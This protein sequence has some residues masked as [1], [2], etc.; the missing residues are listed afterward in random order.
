MLG[1]LNPVIY[2]PTLEYLLDVF[3]DSTPGIHAK[4]KASVSCAV[5]TA[6]PLSFETEDVEM[7]VELIHGDLS[8]SRF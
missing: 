4:E 6:L 7:R 2:V 8:N 5:D 3:C 1:E